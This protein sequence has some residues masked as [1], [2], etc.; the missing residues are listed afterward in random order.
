MQLMIVQRSTDCKPSVIRDARCSVKAAP[1]VGFGSG[2]LETL[3]TTPDF[4][5]PAPCQL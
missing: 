3:A 2:A 4:A 1:N 5:N